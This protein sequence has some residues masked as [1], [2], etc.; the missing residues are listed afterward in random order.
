MTMRIIPENWLDEITNLS[1]S[2][3]AVAAF[4]ITELQSTDR[5]ALWRS[6]SLATQT[7]TGSFAGGAKPVDSWGIFPGNG[8]LAGATAR[9]EL[10]V[11]GSPVYDSGTL[12]VFTFSGTVWGTFAWGG[13][14]WGVEV[15]NRNFRRTP[16]VKFITE[17]VADAFRLTIA[18]GGGMDTD[19]FEADRLWLGQSVLAPY[20]ANTG[21]APSF[22]DRSEHDRSP[23]ASLRVLAMDGNRDVQFDTVFETEADRFAWAQILQACGKTREIVLSLLPDDA[24]TKG[25][26]LTYRGYLKALNPV[27]F[28]NP[29]FHTLQLAI[30]E[31]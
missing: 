18:N 23:G 13:H 31:S 25:S 27:V 24:T 28:A 19:Y 12:D 4:P 30:T 15:S 20:T 10:L 7:I 22:D 11:A 26:D 6:S 17:A 1:V 5:G 14:P 9:M 29:N 8:N 21:L 2:P 3:A 16:L